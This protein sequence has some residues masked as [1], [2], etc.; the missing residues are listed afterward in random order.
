MYTFGHWLID[1][2]HVRQIRSVSRLSRETGLPAARISDWVLHRDLPS[3]AEAAR[4]A[5]YFGIPL[6]R[7]RP[8][9]GDLPEPVRRPA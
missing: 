6:D 4:L 7:L 2:M 3:A 9:T 1:Q 5:R 8:L